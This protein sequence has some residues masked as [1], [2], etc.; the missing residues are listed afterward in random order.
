ME[1]VFFFFFKQKTAYEIRKGDWSSDVCSSDLPFT[2]QVLRVRLERLAVAAA[3]AHRVRQREDAAHALNLARLAPHDAPP[4]RGM[5]A[6]LEEAPVDRHVA[7]VHVEHDD[8]ARGDTD[9]RVP[10]AAAQEMGAGL[11]DPGPALRLKARRRDWA[12]RNRHATIVTSAG[13]AWS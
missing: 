10:C 11:A 8:V 9:H 3:R 13:G 5:I 4:L 1:L 7:P 12:E 6:D 2:R